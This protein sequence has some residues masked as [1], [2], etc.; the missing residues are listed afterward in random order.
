MNLSAQIFRISFLSSNLG[1]SV[2]RNLWCCRWSWGWRVDFKVVHN[3]RSDVVGQVFDHVHKTR[4]DV[5]ERN[6]FVSAAFHSLQVIS[7]LLKHLK[8]ALTVQ[9]HR[10]RAKRCTPRTICTLVAREMYGWKLPWGK[11]CSCLP[12]LVSHLVLHLQ[13]AGIAL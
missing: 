12:S 5:V 4:F 10:K 6:W 7:I 8:C 1:G 2:G 3:K 13:L 11:I 9:L